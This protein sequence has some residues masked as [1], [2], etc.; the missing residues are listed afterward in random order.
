MNL[1][2]VNIIF[3]KDLK[4]LLT[5][6]IVKFSII[7]FPMLFLFILSSVLIISFY[8][9]GHLSNLPLSTF[10]VNNGNIHNLEIFY[11]IALNYLILLSVVP[12]GLS[13]TIASYSIVGEKQ[14][15]TIEPILATPLDDKELFFGK[16]LAPLIP[17]LIASYISIFIYTIIADY[18]SSNLGGII[19]PNIQW[20]IIVFIF[21]PSSTALE[22]LFTL[23]FSSRVTDPRSAQQISGMIILP[24]IIIFILSLFYYSYEPILLSIMTIAV[25]ISDIILFKIAVKLFD[26]ERII[27]RWI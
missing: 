18:L 10:P 17:T 4:E 2:N 26:R 12:L 19:F 20:F 27:T 22:I 3:Q 1:K 13:T 9:I 16:L 11:Y 6:N 23:L 24:I 21:I 25:I 8:Q 14:Q 7:F 15:K 5:L